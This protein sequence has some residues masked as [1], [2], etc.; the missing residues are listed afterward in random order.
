MLYLLLL[1]TQTFARKFG[2]G[3]NVVEDC[4]IKAPKKDNPLIVKTTAEE[5]QA[6]KR[7]ADRYAGGNMSLWVRTSS[8]NYRPPAPPAEDVAG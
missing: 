1:L 8:I 4:L 2:G 5:K 7:N 3:H 6:I